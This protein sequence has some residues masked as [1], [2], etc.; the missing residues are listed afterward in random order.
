MSGFENRWPDQLS[1]GQQQR[2]ALA[3]VLAIKPKVLLLD[4][5]LS[6]LDRN[7]RA[8][9][10]TMIHELQR[11]TGITT[12]FVTHDQVEAIA[13]ADRLALILD[14]KL[15]QVGAVREF[16]DTP[17]DAQVTRF[18]GDLKFIPG[19]NGGTVVRTLDRLREE[20]A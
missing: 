4:E 13:I 6:N 20:P 19:I 5:P 9:L 16:F 8:E 7:L 17:A 1:G 11:A 18:F 15:H 12:I 14:G 3:R 10:R 2:V